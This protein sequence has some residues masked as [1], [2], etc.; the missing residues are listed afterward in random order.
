[1]KKI[2]KAVRVEKYIAKIKKLLHSFEKSDFKENG[3]IKKPSSKNKNHLTN[4]SNKN[5]P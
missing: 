2:Q 4:P 1:L 5:I 3:K